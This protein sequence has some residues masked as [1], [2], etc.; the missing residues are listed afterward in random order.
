MAGHKCYNFLDGFSGYNQLSIREQ[1]KDKTTFITDWGTYAY[2]KMLFGL[3]N[4][5]VNFIRMMNTIFQDHLKRFLEIFIDDFCVFGPHDQHLSHSQQTFDT[6][7]TFVVSESLFVCLLCRESQLSLHP[8][9]CFFFMTS[10]FLLG[11]RVSAEGISV[12]KQKGQSY[13][14]FE[15]TNESL[16]TSGLPRTCGLLQTVHQYV[17]DHYR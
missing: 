11:H 15:S 16:G 12:D 5:H 8:E 9:K 10:G 3:C 6:C 1:D 4:A 14:G 13:P 7:K 17:R 2:H